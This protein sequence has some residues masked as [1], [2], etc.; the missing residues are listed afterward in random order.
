MVFVHIKYMISRSFDHLAALGQ[1][2]SLQDVDHL[3][4]ICHFYT[5]TV[6]VEDVQVDPCYQGIPHGTLLIQEARIGSRFYL[7]PG[8]PFIDDH[9][10]FFF[11]V[12]F[13]HDG[14]VTGNQFVHVPGLFHGL[15]PFFLIKFG[16]ASFV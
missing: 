8:S 7:K 2:H 16:S 15:V 4:D 12:V 3:G 13:V 1:Y 11:R 5:V 10:N 9:S 14:S 6:F